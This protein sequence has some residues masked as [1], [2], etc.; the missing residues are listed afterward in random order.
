MGP[1]FDNTRS[2]SQTAHLLCQDEPCDW[3]GEAASWGSHLLA[4]S[5]YLWAYPTELSLAIPPRRH[6]TFRVHLTK[7]KMFP[8]AVFHWV[9]GTERPSKPQTSGLFL[10]EQK[11]A[12]GF[13]YT[14]S[15]TLSFSCDLSHGQALIMWRSQWDC[16]NKSKLRNLILRGEQY[17][18]TC[19][20]VSQWRGC[21]GVCDPG[22]WCWGEPG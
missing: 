12:H 19:G 11:R 18:P 2:V 21:E 5:V 4:G 15:A 14:S 17:V 16:R 1:W 13:L 7:R 6:T 9:W 10:T 22:D 8:F 3:A 20:L